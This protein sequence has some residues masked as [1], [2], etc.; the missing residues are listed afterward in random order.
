MRRIQDHA[1]AGNNGAF[2]KGEG[3]RLG[4]FDAGA[5]ELRVRVAAHSDEQAIA[6]AER[7][8]AAEQQSIGT[9]TECSALGNLRIWGQSQILVGDQYHFRTGQWRPG[10][11]HR[12]TIRRD[13]NCGSICSSVPDA[14]YEQA[15]G[16]K[17]AQFASIDYDAAEARA[18]STSGD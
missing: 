18:G 9:C 15:F 3:R 6:T 1:H 12:Q 11:V 13:D 7:R 16:P 2:A 14:T 17:S 10:I 5:E 4:G 8:R